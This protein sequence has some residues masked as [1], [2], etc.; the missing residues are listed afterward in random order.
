MVHVVIQTLHCGDMDIG[1]TQNVV[2]HSVVKKFYTQSGD[3]N[4]YAECGDHPTGP[5]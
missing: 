5:V 1:H 4:I 2:I 3:M